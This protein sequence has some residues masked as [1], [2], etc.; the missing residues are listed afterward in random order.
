MAR[1]GSDA[2]VEVVADQIRPR[3]SDAAAAAVSS[4]APS[5]GTDPARTFQPTGRTEKIIA[6]IKEPDL[7]ELSC[8]G[9]VLTYST[10][11][12]TG[13]AR[14][15]FREGQ[16][17]VNASGTEIRTNSTELG[18][19]V[20]VTL[21]VVPDLRTVTITLLVPDINLGKQFEIDFETVAIETTQH[22]G[23]GGPGLVAGPLRTYRVI[24]L[25]GTAKSVEFVVAQPDA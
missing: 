17:E 23:I 21:E 12:I 20:T 10:S 6:I 5:A 16:R 7:Y 24:A 22:T 1:W 13:S 25:H 8:D 15:S 9:V 4:C 3:S 11:S 18:T 2:R 14:F 19:E